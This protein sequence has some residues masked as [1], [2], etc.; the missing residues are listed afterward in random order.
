MK[1]LLFILLCLPMIGFGQAM[2]GCTDSIATNYNPN[3]IENGF[4]ITDTS[5]FGS[6]IN[7]IPFGAILLP[8]GS[9]NIIP[10]LPGIIL[11]DTLSLT[12]TSIF[13]INDT[14]SNGF[15]ILELFNGY[16]SDIS[17]INISI[18]ECISASSCN[19]IGNYSAPLIVSG[20]TFVDSISLNGYNLNNSL[21]VIIDNID[22]NAS[23]GPVLI[24]YY[25]AMSIKLTMT[26]VDM[27]TYIYGCTDSLACNY[28]FSATMD[29]S[30]CSYNYVSAIVS[31]VNVSCN[32]GSNASIIATATGGV[33]PFQYSLSGWGSQSSGTFTN[34]TAGTYYIYVSDINGCT[35]FQTILITEPLMQISY[36]T[37]SVGAS[38]VWNGIPLN[39]SGDYS[40]TLT[41][42]VGCDSIANL[43][44][45]VTTTGISDIANNKNNL[46]KITDMLGQETP[47]RRNTPLFYIYDDG[48]V[49]KRIVIE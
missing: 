20:T 42:S 15:L 21:L 8:D 10:A 31:T 39:V 35:S 33:L 26:D 44:L 5:Y 27:C 46:V 7:E 43:N 49:E 1:K 38:I 9:T 41:N 28:N 3:A 14:I 2:Y 19:A 25:D 40:V 16:P 17:N 37:L 36:D 23:N 29:D 34:L 4:T 22:F 18:L 24:N 32:G 47:Y 30:S 48:T 11:N 12:N 45:T 13:A 6:M